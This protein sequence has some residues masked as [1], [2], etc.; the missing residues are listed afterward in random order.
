ME[1]TRDTALD[2]ERCWRAV[3]AR[4]GGSDGA[5]VY[6]VRSTGLR[7]DW[8]HSVLAVPRRR[9]GPASSSAGGTR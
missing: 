6:A 2:A 1:Q 7:A 4:D 5:F 3:A 8:R 9:R